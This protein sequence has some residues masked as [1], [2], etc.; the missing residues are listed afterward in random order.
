NDPSADGYVWWDQWLG[1]EHDLAPKIDWNPEHFFRFRKYFAYNGGLATDLLYHRLSPLIMAISGHS[2]EYPKRVVASGGIYLEKDDRDIPDTFFMMVDYPSE[3]TVVLSSVMT[4]DDTWPYVIRGQH[5][6]MNF[7][8]GIDLKE[9]GVWSNEFRA[10]NGIET[11]KVRGEDG[12]T[13]DEPGRGRAEVHLGSVPRRDHMG[14][15]L[16]AVRNGDQLACDVDLG[17]SVMVAIK[18]G[19][20]AYRQNKVM[21]WDAQAE[22]MIAT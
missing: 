1:H 12:K 19:V 7:G 5:A 3:H 10:N 13:R 9:Q 2:G 17:C 20:E 14:N 16:D 8:N 11:R 4:N 15:F 18:M 21:R 6:T 22:E